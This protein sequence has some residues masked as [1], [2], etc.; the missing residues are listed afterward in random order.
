MCLATAY[1]N[2]VSEEPILRDIAYM[3]FNVDRVEMKT[4]LGEEQV[5]LGRVLEIDFSTSKII[6]GQPRASTVERN[7]NKDDKA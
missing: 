6:I 3:R 1:L 7:S 2:E 5:I 4:L